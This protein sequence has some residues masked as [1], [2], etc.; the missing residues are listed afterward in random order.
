MLY[1]PL[2]Q[3]PG[4]ASPGRERAKLADRPD[5]RTEEEKNPPMELGVIE[6][7]FEDLIDIDEP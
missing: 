4:P 7:D 1:T 2:P 3:A 5:L 6:G